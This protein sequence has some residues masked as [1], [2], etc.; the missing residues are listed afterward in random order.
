MKQ[1]SERRRYEQ[2]VMSIVILQHQAPLMQT[3]AW[4]I[5]LAPRAG[6]SWPQPSRQ[7]WHPAPATTSLTICCPQPPQPPYSTPTP[8]PSRPR[9]TIITVRWTSKC[10]TFWFRHGALSLPFYV[11]LLALLALLAPL[12]LL[13]LLAPVCCWCGL[14]A[15]MHINTFSRAARFF[16]CAAH[17]WKNPI[18]DFFK[19]GLLF[20][21]PG[22]QR[23]KCIYIQF[24]LHIFTFPARLF[25]WGIHSPLS[26]LLSPLSSF[27]F[28][29]SSFLFPLSTYH[30]GAR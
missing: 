3:T 20:G 22:P 15:E 5:Y 23:R 24:L 12:A 14:R 13:A 27:L 21:T 17:F 9:R 6:W 10:D 8:W 7:E 1:T 26:T 25:F 2:P 19:S 28:P 16:F 30:F 18:S 4:R 11:A 29:L